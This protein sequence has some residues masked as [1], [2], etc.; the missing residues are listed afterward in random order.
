MSESAALILPERSHSVGS[1]LRRRLGADKVKDDFPTI[2]AYSVDAS[3]Y[4]MVPKAVVLAETEDDI[5]A[6]VA[7]ALETGVPITPRA[8]GTNLTGSAVGAG[9]ILDCGRM[10]QILDLNVEERVRVPTYLGPGG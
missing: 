10:R 7:Y 8:A 2:T 9:I 6:T 4:K 3:I 1:D 5:A